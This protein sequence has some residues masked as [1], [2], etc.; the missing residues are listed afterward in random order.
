MKIRTRAISISF[1]SRTTTRMNRFVEKF[2]P[3]VF[4]FS[5]PHGWKLPT[6]SKSASLETSRQ[7]NSHSMSYK[8]IVSLNANRVRASDICINTSQKICTITSSIIEVLLFRVHQG[9][10][11]ATSAKIEPVF[12]AHMSTSQQC[13]YNG[14][15]FYRIS[16]FPIP[17]HNQQVHSAYGCIVS[18]QISILSP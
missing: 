2:L 7:K 17:R 12:S 4:T 5:C 1:T 11:V 10:N 14:D 16:H 3:S 18:Y 8:Y 13:R 9:C 15:K 6:K